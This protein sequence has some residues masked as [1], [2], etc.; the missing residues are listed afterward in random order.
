MSRVPLTV[1]CPA[2]MR[3]TGDALAVQLGT[4]HGDDAA[5]WADAFRPFRVDANGGVWHY[6]T[7]EVSQ[8]FVAA[9]MAGLSQMPG[10]VIWTGDGPVPTATDNPAIMIAVLG[11]PFGAALDAI[12]LMPPPVAL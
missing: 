8:D 4:A 3:A 11:L 6:I 2:D 12:G 9:N 5:G 10:L 1:V 7:Y